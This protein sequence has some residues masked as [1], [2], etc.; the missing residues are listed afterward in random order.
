MLIRESGLLGVPGCPSWPLAHRLHGW[1]AILNRLAQL[2]RR[3]LLAGVVLFS[4]VT[5][6]QQSHA[7]CHAPW[8]EY[9]A[10]G[11][12]MIRPRNLMLATAS[13]LP[14]GFMAPSGADHQLRRVAIGYLRGSY[15]AEPVSIAV[16]YVLLAATGGVYAGALITDDCSIQ[17]T[18]SAVLQGMVNAISATMLLKWMIGRRLP[19]PELDPRAAEQLRHP[20]FAENFRPF[21]RGI[22]GAFPSGHAAIMFAAAAA[23]RASTPQAGVFRY[24]GYPFAIGVSVGMWMG[25][26]HW[27][28]DIISGALLGEALGTASGNAFQGAQDNAVTTMVTP[29][30]G[31]AAVFVSGT[32]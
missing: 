8:Q 15:A 22:K 25:D 3:H 2:A 4:T 24:A 19:N 23:F 9:P 27:A 17:R 14:L 16:P 7:L 30:P 28:S 26:H 13:A 1:V 31:G 29:L 10:V 11:R 12:E 32:L 6:S 20:E 18:T 21:Q 5:Y